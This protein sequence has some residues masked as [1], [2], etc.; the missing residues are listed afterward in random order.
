MNQLDTRRR[1][2]VG[3]VQ[4]RKSI[5]SLPPWAAECSTGATENG[6]PVLRRALTVTERQELNTRLEALHSLVSERPTERAILSAL[7]MLS[8]MS[9]QSVSTVA[10]DI[11]VEVWVTTISDDEMFGNITDWAIEE[12]VRFYLG[13]G[14]GKWMPS[15]GEF[16]MT[17][18][19][20]MIPYHF[21]VIKVRNLLDAPV[22]VAHSEEA[23]QAMRE[24]VSAI[25]AGLGENVYD[26]AKA[27]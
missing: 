21:T 6:L 11:M 13:G 12:A 10:A 26:A 14:G 19:R 5:L 17:A 2:Q 22:Y 3:S 9:K 20:R 7:G 15:A 24:R 25:M 16:A 23:R 27:D 1:N 4:Q 8:T 18:R